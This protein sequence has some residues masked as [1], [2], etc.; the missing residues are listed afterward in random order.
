MLYIKQL[1]LYNVMFQLQIYPDQDHGLN[2]VGRHVYT[3]FDKYITECFELNHN[4]QQSRKRM[5]KNINHN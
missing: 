5:A 4:D 3:T 1:N 2:S